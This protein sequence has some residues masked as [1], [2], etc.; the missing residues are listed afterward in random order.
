M[1]YIQVGIKYTC[2]WIGLDVG[3]GHT[4]NEQFIYLSVVGVNRED[5]EYWKNLLV[6]TDQY[7]AHLQTKITRYIGD[8]SSDIFWMLSGF[9]KLLLKIDWISPGFFTDVA[10]LFLCLIMPAV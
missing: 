3:F 8:F 2:M 1:L 5:L 7:R 6:L 4:R 10:D 9:F